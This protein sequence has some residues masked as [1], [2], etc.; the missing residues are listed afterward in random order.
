MEYVNELYKTGA[1]DEDLAILAKLLKPFAPHLA[2]EMLESLKSD[3][4]WP[5]YEAKYLKADTVEV[6]VQ[7]NGKLRARLAVPVEDVEDNA[8]LE[9]LAKADEKVK[10][11]TD[12]K[13][14]IKTIVVAKSHLVNIV[15]K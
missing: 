8:K 12:G 2:S 14:I 3:D 11:F 13:Q 1:C 5:Q 7:V 9:E 10:T 6:V 15:V 4:V